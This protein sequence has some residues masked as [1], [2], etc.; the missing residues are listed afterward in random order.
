MGLRLKILSGFL[1]LSA[2]LLIAGIWSIYE[3]NSIGTSAQKILDENYQSI[4]AAK[5]MKEAL[6]RQ[7]SAVL[8]LLLGKWTDGR[9]ILNSAD[10]LFKQKLQFA[11]NNSTIP[12]EQEQ[13]QLIQSKYDAFRL[14][15]E[16]PIV[17]TDK[18]GNIEWYFQQVHFSFMIVKESINDLINMN[19]QM[20]YKT[21]KQLENRSNRAIMPGIIAILTALIFTFIFN[22]LVNYYMV[23][24]I[25]EIT[26]RVK[27]FRDKRI[28]FDVQIE[29]KDEIRHLADAIEHLCHLSGSKDKQ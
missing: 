10:S 16:K 3:L 9:S 17:N 6:E 26:D 27:K 20:M 8:L 22:Y 29:T 12:G 1:I 23:S 24:P 28:P 4:L 14:M 13:L 15:W 18:E 25:I 19:D 5:N 21:A 11:L 2:M 7:D